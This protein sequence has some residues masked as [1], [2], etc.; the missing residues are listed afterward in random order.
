MHVFKSLMLIP[1][2]T[3]QLNGSVRHRLKVEVRP[4]ES[5]E[6]LMPP[7]PTHKDKR[8]RDT[9]QDKTYALSRKI[10]GGILSSSRGGKEI[11]LSRTLHA[12]KLDL[13]LDS[14]RHRYLQQSPRPPSQ[15][16][17]SATTTSRN[18]Y[19]P[20]DSSHR[21]VCYQLRLCA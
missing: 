6:P 21:H 4:I 2:G 20:T 19:D 14:R 10:P 12:R 8:C 17:V 5:K 11:Q 13:N 16:F 3:Q 7:C 15:I 18:S 9:P 1:H